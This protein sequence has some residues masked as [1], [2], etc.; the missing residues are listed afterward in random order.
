M[1]DLTAIDELKADL[2]TNKFLRFTNT[3][4]YNKLLDMIKR[5]KE[6][7]ALLK[8]FQSGGEDTEKTNSALQ[9]IVDAFKEK[10]DVEK[11]E[12][13]KAVLE[14]EKTKMEAKI[15]SA[16]KITTGFVLKFLLATSA[17]KDIQALAEE[18]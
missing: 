8:S 17:Y 7:P 13:V 10:I 4:T 2:N 12:A 15:K 5:A 16:R 6:A 3:E 18:M 1:A 14:K 9:S 11:N